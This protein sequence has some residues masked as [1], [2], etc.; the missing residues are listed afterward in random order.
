MSWKQIATIAL[1]AVAAV[2]V[3][4][5]IPFVSGLLNPSTPAK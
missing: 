3:A 4:N 2:A 1:V 5:R